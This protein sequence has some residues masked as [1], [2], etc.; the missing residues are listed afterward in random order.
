MSFRCSPS[1][2]AAETK[3]KLSD[4][5]CHAI[6][7]HNCHSTSH[8]IGQGLLLV[9]YS[10]GCPVFLGSRQPS[11]QNHRTQSI[12]SSKQFCHVVS[13]SF[14]C[15]FC[16][17]SAAAA[18]LTSDIVNLSSLQEW[19]IPR[20]SLDLVIVVMHCVQCLLMFAAF[21]GIDH[22]RIELADGI[23][24]SLQLVRYLT[25]EQDIQNSCSMLF[26]HPAV[27]AWKHLRLHE[28][29]ASPCEE[30]LRRSKP[31]KSAL[32]I[33]P[34][35]HVQKQKPPF[36]IVFK[37]KHQFS[38]TPEKLFSFCS[39]SAQAKACVSECVF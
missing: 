36:Q 18:P 17:F 11:Q 1:I 8:S 33:E 24:Y 16:S 19:Q 15:F 39:T 23:V 27:F 3:A 21:R 29:F 5:I 4:T 9:P 32:S 13:T 6:S 31:S 2:F 35:A 10:S 37:V 12:P 38:R 30:K 28:N 14:S 22:C 20:A 25:R 26:Q 7:H 34:W